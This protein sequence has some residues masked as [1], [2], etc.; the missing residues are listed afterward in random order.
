VGIL[1]IS[2]SMAG[3]SGLE[4]KDDLPQRVASHLLALTFFALLIERSVEV[5]ANNRFIDRE[6][7]ASAKVIQL[8]RKCAVLNK[9]LD[10]E[11]DQPIAAL[12]DP[13]ALENANQTKIATIERLRELIRQAKDE[14]I[15]ADQEAVPERAS[16]AAEK[17]RFAAM[18]ATILGG[19][20]AVTGTTILSEFVILPDPLV[21]EKL[22]GLAD[23]AQMFTGV[24]ILITAVILAGGSDGIHQ[25]IKKFLDNPRGD[26]HTS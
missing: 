2:A 11:L 14:K 25:V 22:W 18:T 6:M 3:F 15:D 21:T 13:D 26:L 16:I 19:L 8:Q 4:F 1:A 17:A 24:D 12:T 23:Q 5:I 10:V 20:I 9:A 7:R